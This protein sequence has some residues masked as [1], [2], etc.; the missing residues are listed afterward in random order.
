[1]I[2]DGI[3]VILI[4]FSSNDVD[5]LMHSNFWMQFAVLFLVA[6]KY[7]IIADLLKFNLYGLHLTL[8]KSLS[9]LKVL[10]SG[11]LS[12]LIVESVV[13]VLLTCGTQESSKG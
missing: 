6:S 12:L 11:K 5:G 2:S 7:P 10:D 8:L 4:C 1:M 3:K 9:F 13:E